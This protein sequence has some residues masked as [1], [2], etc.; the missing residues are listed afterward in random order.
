MTTRSR[1]CGMT[2]VSQEQDPRQ[3]PADAV[4]RLHG[5]LFSLKEGGTFRHTNNLV[6]PEDMLLR[7][8][9]WSREDR[10]CVTPFM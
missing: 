2:H 3:A 9:H 4:S 1:P 5:L 7:E 8:G 6:N 10:C